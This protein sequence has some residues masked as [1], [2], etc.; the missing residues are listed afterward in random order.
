MTKRARAFSLI[1]ILLT[2]AITSVVMA[3]LVATFSSVSR[4]VNNTT[5][6]S[7]QT[8]TVRGLSELMRKDF[9]SAG[10]G[11]GDLIAYDIRYLLSESLTG[12]P[13]SDGTADRPIFFYGVSDIDYGD[14]GGDSFSSVTLQWFEYD[15]A[16]DTRPTFFVSGNDWE[17]SGNYQGPVVLSS[18]N[19]NHVTDLKAGDILIFYKLRL[20][21]QADA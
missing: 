1:E 14:V 4:G 17:A 11:V 19:P 21:Y 8:N 13:V 10:Q 2:L 5:K 15:Y 3:G 20:M 9:T 16:T 18:S 6:K 7:A 12:V